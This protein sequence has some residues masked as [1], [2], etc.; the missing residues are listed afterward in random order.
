MA[1]Q[2][3]TDTPER[4]RPLCTYEVEE[5]TTLRELDQAA[6]RVDEPGK[7]PIW[8]P[9]AKSRH[10]FRAQLT[11]LR[12]NLHTLQIMIT[13]ATKAIHAKGFIT[14][15]IQQTDTYYASHEK[16]SAMLQA[17]QILT[18]EHRQTLNTYYKIINGWGLHTHVAT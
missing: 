8:E 14:E 1:G 3:I 9:T 13:R 7:L 15:T 12:E 17:L 6:Q 2:D 10:P 18:R 4:K 5:L 16:P 11:M